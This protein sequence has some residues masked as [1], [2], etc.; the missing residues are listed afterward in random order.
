MKVRLPGLG[1][2]HTAGPS[3]LISMMLQILYDEPQP[4]Q[5]D[6]DEQMGSY[7]VRRLDKN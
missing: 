7:I 2:A 6:I 4:L 5:L 1:F 3:L